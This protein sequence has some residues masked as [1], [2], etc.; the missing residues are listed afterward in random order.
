VFQSGPFNIQRDSL[1][2]DVGPGSLVVLSTDSGR[3]ILEK[4]LDAPSHSGF[5][6]QDEFLIFGTGYRNYNSTGSLY[7]IC[8]QP[9]GSDD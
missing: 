6:I 5:A 2:P 1:T 9:F 7:V 8:V 4:N 3:V